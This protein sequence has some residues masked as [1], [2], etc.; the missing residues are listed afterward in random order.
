MFGFYSGCDG[1]FGKGRGAGRQRGRDGSGRGG[2]FREHRRG[3]GVGPG[4]DCG[5]GH[6]HAEGAEG[7][8]GGDARHRLGRTPQ[9]GRH[10]YPG[11][12]HRG[13]SRPRVR[14]QHDAGD[15]A[16]HERLRRQRGAL[17]RGRRAACR[18]N[19]GQ[20]G[21]QPSEPRRRGARGDSERRLVGPVRRQ[22]RGWCGE[23]YF[24]RGHGAVAS[25]P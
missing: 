3:R 24:A 12:A 23:P 10:Q 9:G 2:T 7:C 20:C 17:P 21:L 18:R 22:C 14:L 4:G 11:P 19:Y 15:V 1:R 16:E 8:A 5:D 6:A 25:R 13:D